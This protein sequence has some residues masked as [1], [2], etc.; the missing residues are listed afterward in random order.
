MYIKC[1]FLIIIPFYFKN[2]L[3]SALSDDNKE[4]ECEKGKWGAR[5]ESECDPQ[6]NTTIINCNKSTG[7]C[8]NCNEK[9]YSDKTT[10]LCLPCPSQCKSEICHNDGCKECSHPK[11]YDNWCNKTCDNCLKKP[12][13][14]EYCKREDGT[15]LGECEKGFFGAK[16]TER[17]NENC[18]IE[19]RNCI[20]E[21]GNC[22]NCKEGFYP[23]NCE[24]CP[25]TCK[26]CV[27][28]DICTVCK[29]K[30]NYGILCDKKCNKNCEET[31]DDSPVCDIESGFCFSCQDTYFGDFCTESCRD[32]NCLKCQQK[33]GECLICKIDYYLT[34]EKECSKCKE[35][36]DQCTKE[37]CI[38]CRNNETYGP[39][40]TEKCPEHCEYEEGERKCDR[41]TGNCKRCE[42]YFQGDKCDQCISGRYGENC[43]LECKKG[44]DIS[45]KNCDIS[46]GAC[47]FCL[48][49]YW[50]SLCEYNCGEN[51]KKC[52]K[53]KGVC[54][55]CQYGYYLDDKKSC[56]QCPDNCKNGCNEKGNCNGC[57]NGYWGKKCEEKCQEHCKDN[58]CN[59]EKGDCKCE[60]FFEGD[61]CEHCVFN[62]TGEDCQDTCNIGCNITRVPKINCDQEG[63]CTCLLG[64]FKEDCSEKC[65]EN[66]DYS[67]S[68]CE[69]EKG[70]CSKCANG[71]YTEYCNEKCLDTNCLEC[72]IKTGECEICKETFYLDD[73]KC[74]KCPNTCKDNICN[75]SGCES[76]ASMKQYD[77]FCDKDCPEHCLHTNTS[78]PKCERQGGK[79]IYG[80]E[81]NFDGPSCDKCVSKKYGLDCTKNCSEGCKGQCD[82]MTGYCQECDLKYWGERCERDCPEFCDV[83]TNHCAKDT[84]E[85]LQCLPGYFNKTCEK[86]PDGCSFECTEDGCKS[87]GDNKFGK[88]CEQNC[89]LFCKLNCD[90]ETGD[91]IGCK[92]GRYTKTCL[93]ECKG[94]LN[95]C[96]QEEGNCINKECKPNYYAPEKCNKQ[97]EE[98]CKGKC[99]LFTGECLK[100]PAGTWGKN[101]NDICSSECDDDQR[102]ECCYAKSSETNPTINFE[103]TEYSENKKTFENENEFLIMN[104]Y[105]GSKQAKIEA[106]IDFDSNSPL[107]VIDKSLSPII[108]GGGDFSD[109]EYDSSVSETFD[110]SEKEKIDSFFSNINVTGEI[111][112]DKAYIYSQTGNK[113]NFT[114]RFVKPSE[115]NVEPQ[116]TF[117]H[118]INAIVGLGFLNE[119]SY[120]LFSAGLIQK[121][122]MIKRRE[123]NTI[124][125][126]FGDYPSYIRKDFMKLATIEPHNDFIPK[127]QYEIKANFKG[128][129]YLYTKAYKLETEAIIH[130]SKENEF[131]FSDTFQPFFDK[132]YFGKV[133]DNGCVRREDTKGIK[134]YSCDHETYQKTTFP[135]LGFIIDDYIYYLSKDMLF[136]QKKEKIEF[137]IILK[138]SS[139]IVLG[140]EFLSSY[141]LVFNHGSKTLNLYGETKKLKIPITDIPE[142]WPDSSNNEWLTP[143]TIAVLGVF[144]II[145]IF[146]TIYTFKYC[147]KRKKQN[148]EFEDSILGNNNH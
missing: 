35:S 95:G 49:G 32:V 88:W 81:T 1:L 115:I 128:F 68:N 44:C 80:C 116:I 134:V 93:K 52:D 51:C 121:N 105:L 86:C 78:L 118:P 102:V 108:T 10:P 57:V 59:Q 28:K 31:I 12:T 21:T 107:I 101:C 69:K 89:S 26:S 5:C 79:C 106:L 138:S 17:C 29:S 113:V 65:P 72:D 19:K 85:C 147:S 66:C 15:C 109:P 83:S 119:F 117:P 25:D 71:Y 18:D 37:R 63:K 43:E 39:F 140:R 135:L 3:I 30:Y 48:E 103:L 120:D 98:N 84:G 33:T 36:C 16:C 144:L 73:N 40:C 132:I 87:C 47:E 8:E 145:L 24:D 75:K 60:E 129:T 61:K 97:C 64:F 139:K 92:P 148:E 20:K 126:L 56:I 77:I 130:H 13:S 100:C 114:V 124:N 22:E 136:H 123:N 74:K 9:Y 125:I 11:M 111:V 41:D 45:K 143:G 91:C 67:L 96:T 133:L 2:I 137:K 112:K 38:N 70:T 34:D 110:Q 90:K 58:I 7:V 122:I 53:E 4:E 55:E 14:G 76:C 142:E 99:N 127:Q 146:I 27:F 46:S 82:R 141:A 104:L 54:S 42:E 23:P 131:M 62:H 50:G 94:C 6:C